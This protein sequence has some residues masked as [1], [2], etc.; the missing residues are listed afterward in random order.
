MN[1]HTKQHN[2]RVLDQMR[3]VPA[4]QELP[5]TIVGG[6]PNVSPQTGDKGDLVS[7]LRRH[8]R[9]YASLVHGPL[10]GQ[11]AEVIEQYRADS[12][13]DEQTNNEL[14]A[15]LASARKALELLW[16]ETVQSGNST[17]DDYGW[18][19]AREATLAVLK[20]ARS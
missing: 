8:E 20:D 19:K 11:A 9:D 2:E 5:G 16:N 15:Q 14:R 13:S 12:K 18:P 3:G 6:N 10:C 7:E 17:A 1:Q 4:N